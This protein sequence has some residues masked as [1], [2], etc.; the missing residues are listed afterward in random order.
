VRHRSIAALVE[1]RNVER[2]KFLLA[3]TQA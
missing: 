1:R 3:P 2:D